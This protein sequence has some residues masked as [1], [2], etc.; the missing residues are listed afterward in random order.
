MFPFC[1]L[2]LHRSPTLRKAVGAQTRRALG[3]G[4]AAH[5][6]WPKRSLPLRWYAHAE[7]AG[8]DGPF[9]RF[10]AQS[11][12]AHPPWGGPQITPTMALSR[13]TKLPSGACRRELHP[14][15]LSAGVE[16]PCKACGSIPQALA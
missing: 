12:S 7:A 14:Q 1:S 8:S 5:L 9:A 13:A 15:R 3:R 6:R 2:L 11:A 4:R 10:W 16:S